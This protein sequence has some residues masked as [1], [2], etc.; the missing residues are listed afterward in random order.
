MREHTTDF[1]R[2]EI[3]HIKDE[4]EISTDDLEGAAKLWIG[5]DYVNFIVKDFANLNLPFQDSIDRHNT[6]RM[7]WHD[8]SCVVVGSVARDVARHFIQ[9][10]NFTK[11]SKAK[12]NDRFPWLVP[13]CYDDIESIQIPPYLSRTHLVNCQVVIFDCFKVFNKYLIFSNR[14]LRSGS[15]W[16]IGICEKEASIVD[17]YIEAINNAEHYIYIENQFFISQTKTHLESSDIVQNRIAEAIYRRIIRSFRNKQTFRV[18]ILIP[19]L[20]AFEG[21]LGTSTGAPIQQ[22]TH[23]NYSTIVK[24][25]DSLL[26]KL[27]QEIDDPSQYI[28]FYSLRTFDKLNGRLVTEL[29]YIHR[30]AFLNSLNHIFYLI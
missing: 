7:P 17:A 12:F 30:F 25:Y 14:Q 27:R 3:P 23:Y 29:I 28:G 24:G 18:Y 20:P 6:P 1:I 8:L 11:F 15:S 19:L 16:S 9:R 26:E 4:V 13:Q 22:I 21:E 5:K 2:Q 10:W